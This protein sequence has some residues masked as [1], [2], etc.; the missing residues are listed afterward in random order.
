MLFALVDRVSATK[1][2]VILALNRAS[3]RVSRGVLQT[4]HDGQERMR[5]TA[6]RV[7]LVSLTT[8]DPAD[9]LRGE[10][11]AAVLLQ[12]VAGHEPAIARVQARIDYLTQEIDDAERY[13]GKLARAR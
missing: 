12:R 1:V 11:I 4:H 10:E 8:S 13:L 7:R 9:V 6:A 3:L 2:R 5:E